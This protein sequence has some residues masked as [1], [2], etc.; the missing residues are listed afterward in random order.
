MVT[1]RVCARALLFVSAL[2][3]PF[4]ADS[5]RARAADPQPYTV[6]ITPTGDATLDG[7]LRDSSSLISLREK[8]P[9]GAFALIARSQDD[10]GRLQTALQ[11]Y[12]YY[13]GTAHIVIAGRQLDDPALTGLIDAAPATTPVKVEVTIERGPQFH[14][15]K[16]TVDGT[17][18]AEARGKLGL[19]SGQPALAA[20]VL[21]ARNRLETALQ[22]EGHALA[23]VSPPVAYEDASANAIDVVYKVDAGPRADIGPISLDGLKDVNPDFVRRRLLVHQGQLFQPSAI[24]TARQDLTSVGVFSSVQARAAGQLNQMNQMPVTFAFVERPRHAV[25]FG[26]SYSTDL[27]GSVSTSWTNRNLFGNAESLTL[28]AAATEL[29]GTASKQPGYDIGATFIKPDFRRRDQALQINA[30][31]L[32]EYLEAY[33]RTA[34]I[35]GTS[36]NRK[37][38]KQLTISAGL[39]GTQERVAQEGVTRDYTLIGV[40]LV[41]KYD[42]S[43]NLFEPTHGVRANATVTPTQSF[44]GAAANATFVLMQAQG[45]TYLDLSGGGRSVLALRALVGVAL[46]AT[47]FELPPDQR[48]YGGG[49]ANIRGYKY[50]SVG[51]TFPDGNPQGGTAIDAATVEFRQRIG[52]SFGAALFVDAGQVSANGGPFTGPLRV[53]AGTGARYYTPIGPIRLDVAL[54]L[55]KQ[56]GNDAFELYIGIG[57]A[58]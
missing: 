33:N 57:E 34:Y 8:A 54:P 25:N 35:V 38:T 47:Q 48:F 6:T 4:S 5:G 43:D 55:I 27:G 21:A 23:T 46:G 10:V 50:Q 28:S 45:S 53:G 26:A 16:I 17:I 42:T 2:L 11:S 37:V 51:P 29:G 56:K 1:P 24:E 18:P 52:A 12:G 39:T 30:E 40:P 32:K 31:A 9:V 49:S 44:G 14:L 20:N 19:E 36:L 3:V 7:A 22:E 13:K 41:A 15:G 58:F